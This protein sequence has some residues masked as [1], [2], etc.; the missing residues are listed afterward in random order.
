MPDRPDERRL[1]LG[2]DI[3]GT[4]TVV[5]LGRATG[6]ILAESRLEDWS[7]GSWRT[8][9]DTL[10]AHAGVLLRGAGV[11]PAGL[12]AIG[13]SVPGPLD[14]VRGVVHEAP[15]LPG[16]VD[17]P[18]VQTMYDAFGVQILL[19]NDANAA[20]L[21]EWRFGAGRG[22]RNM[23]YATMSTG[24]GAGLILDGRL[25]R[26]SSFGAGE[27]GHVPIHRDGRATPDGLRGVLEA[28]A[29]G[30]AL[31]ER[32]REDVAA[33]QATAILE[34][35]GGDPAR[36][37][38]RTWVEAIRAGDAYARELQQG[39]VLD[40]AQGLGGAIMLLDPD[41]V[42][43]GT[44]VQQNPDLF[45]EPIREATRAHLWKPLHHVRIEP[46]ELGERMPAYAALSVGALEPAELA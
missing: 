9:V 36:I 15:N 33:G 6:E 44:I 38:A 7:R 34:L 26:G 30:A 11:E 40:V 45:L 39:F 43:L 18:L 16:W 23:I 5:A 42:V 25:Y 37:S 32:I 4:K 17:V 24:I 28:Y 3:G 2:I 12:H 21:A 31:A 27:L 20:A 14:P 8:D 10:V 41:V 22:S 1:L 35:A 19:E 13:L 46:G 29:G